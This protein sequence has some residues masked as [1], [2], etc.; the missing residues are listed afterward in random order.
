MK[1][2]AQ[3]WQI[4]PTDDK[5]QNFLSQLLKFRLIDVGRVMQVYEEGLLADV[6][7]FDDESSKVTC[8]VVSIG[9]DEASLQ[10]IQIGQFVLVFYPASPVMLHDR[11]LDITAGVYSKIYAKCIPLGVSKSD[12]GMNV[13]KDS[14]IFSAPDYNAYL[15]KS[16]ISISSQNFNLQ[17]TPASNTLRINTPATNLVVDDTGVKIVRGAEWGTDGSLTNSKATIEI[18]DEGVSVTQ[19]KDNVELKITSDGVS[20]KTDKIKFDGDVEITGNL[21][22]ANGNF[23]AEV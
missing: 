9:T 10:D 21:S 13:A 19:N 5:S 22:A 4:D 8:E 11:T 17:I 1:T 23:T 7:L 15:R 18:N 14:I 3:N 16:L 12:V 6:K 2:L 20:V